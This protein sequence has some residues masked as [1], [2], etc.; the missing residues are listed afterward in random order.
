MKHIFRYPK[1]LAF[2]ASIV[3]AYVL[4]KMGAF[5]WIEAHL[6]GASYPSMILA[7]L[8]FSFGFTSPLAAAY[9]YEVSHIVNPFLAAILA[10]AGA[11]LSDISIFQFTRLSFH[12]EIQRLKETRLIR[13]LHGLFHHDGIS[14][15]FR[16]AL[17]WI[18][19][20]I[21][22]ASPLPDEVGMTFVVGFTNLRGWKLASLCW[23]LN[24][25]GILFIM[26]LGR[27]AV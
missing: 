1:L 20:C 23:G 17:R 7:G 10:A 4:F 18:L 3:F 22:I 27:T 19:A 13:W 25:V 16:S 9:F 21:V 26:L 12:D 24:T 8:F 2:F 15:D 11:T 5:H 6:D 14:H